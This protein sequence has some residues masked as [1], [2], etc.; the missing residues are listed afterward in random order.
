MQSRA[1][2]LIL[3]QTPPYALRDQYSISTLAWRRRTSHLVHGLHLGPSKTLK[4]FLHFPFT[5]AISSL[6]YFADL[7][8]LFL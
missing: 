6:N 5:I 3:Q 1:G 7:A 2:Q 4:G 8:N